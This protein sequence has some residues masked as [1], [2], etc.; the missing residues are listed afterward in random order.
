MSEPKASLLPANSSPLE[1]ALDLGFGKLLD[2]A[3]R[4]PWLWRLL[5]VSRL[6][7]PTGR[8]ARRNWRF[9]LAV[10]VVTR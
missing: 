2:R 5:K 7:R 6:G 10:M 1:K 9:R 8:W 3:V 4:K